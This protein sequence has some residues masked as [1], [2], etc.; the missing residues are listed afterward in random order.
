LDYLIC[1][2]FKNKEGLYPGSMDSLEH[3]VSKHWY[4]NYPFDVTY[5]HNSRGFRDNEWPE[6]LSSVIW[7]LGDSFT[8]GISVP[9]EHT[10][11]YV[12][13]T[14]STIRC[15]N[16]G[17]DG[18]SNDY[19]SKM[20]LQIQSQYNPKHIVIMW[21]FF[22][23]R[24]EDHYTHIYFDQKASDQDNL[25]NFLHNYHKINFNYPNITNLLIPKQRIDKK[26]SKELN[27]FANF[28]TLDY[29]RDGYHFGEKTANMI[30]DYIL[31][32]LNTSL[33]FP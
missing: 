21:S 12:L 18:L 29:G 15:L 27:L 30:V 3:C 23:R 2:S 10:W 19:I 16:L 6:D 28:P 22:H 8:H 11:P 25:N 4:L 14:R 31:Y 17:M 1:P 7:C 33:S 5:Y 20:A 9:L 24:H 26:L 32:D 13:K